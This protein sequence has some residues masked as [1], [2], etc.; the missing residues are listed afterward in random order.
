MDKT[1]TDTQHIDAERILASE[2]GMSYLAGYLA[3][4]SGSKDLG[5]RDINKVCPTVKQRSSWLSKM[6]SGG[7]MFPKEKFL[8]DVIKMEE[9]F[10]NIHQ[11]SKDGLSREKGIVKKVVNQLHELFPNYSVKLLKKFAMTRTAIRVRSLKNAL[12]TYKHTHRSLKKRI[13][14]LF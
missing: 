10:R 13:E 5:I 11:M 6:S 12:K 9:T 14:Y 1:C 8:S 3:F 4:A 7:L 2:E